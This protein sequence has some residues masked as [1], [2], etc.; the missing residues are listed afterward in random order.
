VDRHRIIAWW[1]IGVR[2][3]VS[4]GLEEGR[5]PPGL[6]AGHPWNGFKAVSGVAHPKGIEGSAMAGLSDTLGS[7]W[8]PL[9]IR[10]WWNSIHLIASRRICDAMN[11]DWPF[12]CPLLRK[13]VNFVVA[14]GI[15]CTV[16]CGPREGCTCIR[17]NWI[18]SLFDPKVNLLWVA[19]PLPCN[20]T[21]GGKLPAGHRDCIEE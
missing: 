19:I 20:K 10:L 2:R 6:R 3:G 1:I 18:W 16:E 14:Y 12:L 4:K 9:A 13:M 11:S 17:R 21:G 15:P 7:P 5:N 8:P